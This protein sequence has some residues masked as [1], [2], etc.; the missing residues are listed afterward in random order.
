[1]T[2]RVTA[3]PHEVALRDGRSPGE[4][5]RGAFSRRQPLAGHADHPS[6]CCE[7]KTYGAKAKITASIMKL[8]SPKWIRRTDELKALQAVLERA[9][10]TI[11]AI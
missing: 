5:L 7:E 2:C 9:G 4:H 11:T 8:E 1:M 10:Q 6:G 3:N